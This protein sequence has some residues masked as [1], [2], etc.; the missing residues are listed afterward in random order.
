MIK[1]QMV[2]LTQHWLNQTY[3]GKLGYNVIIED[4][5]TGWNTIGALITA[6]QIEEGLTPDGSF[7][8]ATKSACPTLSTSSNSSNLTV[9]HEI[10]ILQGALYCKG[11]NPNGLDG[12]YGNGA[13]TAIQKFQSDAGLATQDGIAIPMIFE[14]LLNMD[15]FV[16][17][18]NGDTNIRTIQQNLNRD[19]NGIIGLIACD[20]IYSRSTNIA[21]LEAFQAEEG[22]AS[23]NGVFG[24]NTKKLCP[25]IPGTKAT[26]NYILLLQYALYCNGYNPNGFDG[27]FG[28]G[29][30]KAII[31]FQNFV[32]LTADG[33][34][35]PQTWASLLV[36][37]GDQNRTCTVCDCSTTI[38]TEIAATLKANG[39]N[40]VGRY[41]TGKYAMTAS[42]LST[43]FSSGLKVFPIFEYSN[44]E[45][46]FSS[47]QGAIDAYRASV[48]AISLGFYDGTTIYFSVDYDASDSDITVF[49]IPY[50]EG[51]NNK[52]NNNNINYKIGIYGPRN[53]CSKVIAKG[54][55]GQA[56]VSDMSS[57]FSG[58]LGY[59]LP[60]LWAFDQ[61]NTVK[62]GSG[63]GQIE[64]DKDVSSGK[65]LG[66]SR[67]NNGTISTIV[68][69]A[70][71]TGLAK[72]LGISFDS[73]GDP[74]TL[75]NTSVLKVDLELSFGS[76]IGNDSNTLK[77]KNGKF[78]D[79]TAQTA[80]ETISAGVGS[81]GAAEL[82]AL[83]GKINSDTEVYIGVSSNGNSI[84]I[85]LE[86][87]T[88]KEIEDKSASVQKVS[89]TETLNI[90]L[91][92]DTSDTGA[93][94]AQSFK[95]AF[96]SV[97]TEIQSKLKSLAT[98]GIVGSISIYG[99]ESSVKSS[100]PTINT[101][102]METMIL[103][104]IAVLVLACLLA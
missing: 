42:E 91:S 99:G 6:L 102:L 58:N 27:L 38:T 76:T 87:E 89:I 19:Y 44:S 104:L 61:I 29:L 50:F 3:T 20:G 66:V 24:P 70:N 75:I 84:T 60:T 31:D 18:S 37:Y 98:L 52:F 62:I 101:V 11:Y 78:E 65:D 94:V 56:F 53:V 63:A 85:S 83:L 12:S 68:N 15:A 14:A 25:T 57:G 77:F 16:L 96:N 86:T 81:D 21:L 55:A 97:S 54:F 8:P 82:T 72:L 26:K 28:N 67:V 69:A 35:G 32:G 51:I 64:I 49:I 22:I 30:K 13:K 95:S 92:W 93:S 47:L 9:K 1:D 45:L 90:K 36:S 39:Y 80:F 4:G 71:S 79:A 33:S 5:F 46:Y 34:A 7:G 10:L 43:I 88:T 73:A 48:A 41:L 17:L 103:C 2:I 23:P 74:I 59:N 100:M 40:I